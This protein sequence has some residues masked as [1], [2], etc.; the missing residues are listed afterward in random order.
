MLIKNVIT[1][2]SNR[3]VKLFLGEICLNVLLMENIEAKQFKV[4]TLHLAR[5]ISTVKSVDTPRTLY[6]TTFTPY[7]KS[8]PFRLPPF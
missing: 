1:F 2:L 5:F 3:L 8:P 4:Y 6:S 7:L